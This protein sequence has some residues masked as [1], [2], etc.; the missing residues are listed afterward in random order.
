MSVKNRKTKA[1]NVHPTRLVTLSS[2]PTPQSWGQGKASECLGATTKVIDLYLRKEV[3]TEQSQA[4]TARMRTRLIAQKDIP[5]GTVIGFVSHVMQSPASALGLTTI[6]VAMADIQ[7]MEPEEVKAAV[8]HAILKKTLMKSDLMRMAV[9]LPDH[10]RVD[11]VTKEAQ[12]LL[13]IHNDRMEKAA[14]TGKPVDTVFQYWNEGK[15]ALFQWT[16]T[17]KEIS[18]AVGTVVENIE[19]LIAEAEEKDDK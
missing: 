19:A 10:A 13:G 2:S 1:Y 15:Q 3:K 6:K 18:T 11:W 5:A 4:D 14:K 12:R 9:H 17:A 16:P 7:Y 8:L